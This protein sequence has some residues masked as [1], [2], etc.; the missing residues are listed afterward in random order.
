MCTNIL[1]KRKI[2][3]ER[4]RRSLAIPFRF[5]LPLAT[6]HFPL[7]YITISFYRRV[8]PLVSEARIRPRAR[9]LPF[10]RRR[11]SQ[12]PAPSPS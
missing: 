3:I 7:Q 4:H 10:A 5:P 2:H 12:P 8:L 1:D 9:L 6:H 11:V